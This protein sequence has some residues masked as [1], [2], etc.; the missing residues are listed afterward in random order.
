V[1]GSFHDLNG[2]NRSRY[3]DWLRTGRLGFD[4]R[5]DKIF[6]FST[7]SRHALGP[8]EPPIQWLPGVKWSERE[9]DH[10]PSSDEVKNGGAIPPLP[11]VS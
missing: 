7:A 3:S 5:H 9:A 10:S 6:L 2:M 4:S 11:H 8:T 1:E